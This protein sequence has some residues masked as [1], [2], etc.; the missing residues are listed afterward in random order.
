MNNQQIDSYIDIT[1]SNSLTKPI[2]QSKPY[3]APWCERLFETPHDLCHK[4][5]R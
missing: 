2:S 3:I 5:D 4:Q 1:Q